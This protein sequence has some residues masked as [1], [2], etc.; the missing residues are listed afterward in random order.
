M[1]K[2]EKLDA[3]V[4]NPDAYLDAL[5]PTKKELNEIQEL[6][7]IRANCHHVWEDHIEY[8]DLGNEYHVEHCELC[9]DYK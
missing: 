8:D 7:L 6:E 5:V 9:G 4:G 3:L 2:A 1:T